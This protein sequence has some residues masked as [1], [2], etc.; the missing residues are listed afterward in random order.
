MPCVQDGR[1]VTGTR[2]AVAA[3]LEGTL[4]DVGRLR[5]DGDRACLTATVDTGTLPPA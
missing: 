4:A 1:D 2:G 3:R 5:T